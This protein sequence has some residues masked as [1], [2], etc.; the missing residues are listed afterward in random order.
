MTQVATTYQIDETLYQRFD[1]AHTA[2]NL[3]SVEGEQGWR[4]EM[5]EVR[6]ATLTGPST[7]V[8]ET[9]SDLD[10]VLF[11]HGC[12]A[13]FGMI[14]D[15]T[16]RSSGYAWDQDPPPDDILA[17]RCRDPERL[18]YEVRRTA[19]HLGADLVG[20]TRL[21]PRWVYSRAARRAGIGPEP[22][23]KEIRLVETE[24]PRQTA[25]AL[26]L[27][28]R[29]KY[30]IVLGVAMDREMI[31]TAPGMLADAATNLGYSKAAMCTI[32]LAA[33]IRAIGYQAIAT[34]NDTALS[35]PLAID[36]GLG[37]LGR[38]GLLITP[39]FGA[40]VRLAKV[41]TDMP[42]V[43]DAPRHMGIADF[44][45]TCGRCADQCPAQAISD[46]QPTWRGHNVCNNDGAFKW[47]VDGLK[48]L[49]Y[50]TRV[51]TSCSVCIAVCPFT[52]GI[53]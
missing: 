28:T 53:A 16:G 17:R 33:Y 37:E 19:H 34:L 4:R 11:S 3:L 7:D 5:R 25:D 49:R 13:S 51:G 26:I 48:C 39:Q 20:V 44:C 14:D 42:L 22:P 41:I 29:L 12:S 47:Y 9:G 6:Q 32:T 1:Q 50:W 27:P 15:L 10:G 24:R 31:S 23:N 46:G 43:V 30:A 45:E 52:R 38:L 21:D 35:I 36:A 8:I 40:C 2:F 18:T